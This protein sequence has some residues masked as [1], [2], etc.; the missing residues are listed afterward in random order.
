VTLENLIYIQIYIGKKVESLTKEVNMLSFQLD[1]AIYIHI[2]I[3]LYL[4]IHICIHILRSIYI[5]IHLYTYTYTYVIGKKVESLTK[6]VNMLSFQLD[7][8][9]RYNRYFSFH[10]SA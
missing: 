1:K 10:V 4:Y 8:A 6:E 2:Y 5:Y 9:Q 3:Y 7:E